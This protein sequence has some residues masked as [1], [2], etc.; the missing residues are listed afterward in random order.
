MLGV[1]FD[2]ITERLEECLA[3]ETKLEQLDAS[4]LAKAFRGELVPQ[5]STDEPA[6]VLLERVRAAREAASPSAAP[7][8]QRIHARRA[9]AAPP[10]PRTTIAD[11]PGTASPFLVRAANPTSFIDLPRADQLP[12]VH[13]ALRGVGPVPTDAAVRLVADHLRERHLA[14]FSRLRSDGPLYAAIE[15]TLDAAVRAKVLDRPQRGHV[16]ALVPNPKDYTD[17]DWRRCLEGALADR[18]ETAPEP[19]EDNLIRAAAEWAVVNMGLVHQRLRSGGL[20]HQGL[21]RA[22]RVGV[23]AAAIAASRAP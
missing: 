5:D 9:A 4:I 18:A 23:R 8:Q 2:R 22:L 3:A 15:K 12:L 7:G 17:A 19:D 20:V 1:G 6:T 21:S 10:T 11:A 14:D 13:A 16:R